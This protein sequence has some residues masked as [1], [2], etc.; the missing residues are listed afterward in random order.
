M[1][2]ASARPPARWAAK[3]ILAIAIAATALGVR[4]DH[5]TARPLDFHPARQYHSAQ[6][7]RAYYV[8]SSAG[9]PE[10]KTR[11]ASAYLREDP[12]IEAPTLEAVAASAYWLSR[13]ERLWLPRLFSSLFWLT[14]GLFLYLLARRFVCW[15]AALVAVGMYLF[16]P[17]PLVA[18]T[19]FQPDPLMTMLLTG[20]ILGIV[21]HH[22]LPTRRRFVAALALSAIAIFA[23]PVIAAF[24]L[25]PLFGALTIVRDGLRR[26]LT[27]PLGYAFAGLAVLP[28]AVFYVVGAITG[29]FLTG[30][31][32]GS[33][34]LGLWG[35][36]FYWRGWLDMLEGVLRAPGL[37]GRS[38][39]LALAV[40]L[41]AIPL[42]RTKTER[43]IILALWVG[44]AVLGLTYTSHISS[45]DYYS[46]PLVPVVALSVAVAIAALAARADTML[47]RRP[48]QVALVGPRS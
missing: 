46:L 6:I 44:Y 35:E 18:S 38:A 21:R 30:K 34:A 31:V 42:S 14:G 33:I 12:P 37:G 20:A 26:A 28:A 43:A 13:D 24:F 11:I 32:R 10:W 3:V 15:W 17:F 2:A 23:K 47:S 45:H 22:E 25:I 4:W 9:M 40:G 48:V 27:H 19:S 36:S 16:L 7:A 29:S 39:L 41:L 5:I 1:I 8:K